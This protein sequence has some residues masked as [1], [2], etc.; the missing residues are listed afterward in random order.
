MNLRKHN[1]YLIAVVTLIFACLGA[2]STASTQSTKAILASLEP[3]SPKNR[4][5]VAVIPFQFKGEQKQYENLSKKMVDLAMDELF[6]TGRFRIVERNRIDAVLQELKLSQMGIIDSTVANNIG[7]QLGAEMI[8]LGTLTSIKPIKKR[9]S[10][11]VMW[12]ETRGFEITLQARLIDIVHGE[13]ASTARAT[14]MEAQEEKMALG[15]KTGVI[16]PEETLLNKALE[17]AIKILI[18]DLAQKITPKQ[19]T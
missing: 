2:C 13:L 14:G 15:A 6:N 17:S 12:R 19:G 10:L 1:V 4:Y 5:I 7:K 8:L 9:D 11:G 16:A 18:H 3:F